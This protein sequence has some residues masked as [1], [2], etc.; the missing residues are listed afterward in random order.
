MESIVVS[1]DDRPYRIGGSFQP[2]V[3]RP[4]LPLRFPC[5][6][7]RFEFPFEYLLGTAYSAAHRAFR[8][9]PV[10]GPRAAATAGRTAHI[11][12][13]AGAAT[14]RANQARRSHAADTNLH[15]LHGIAFPVRRSSQPARCK[16]LTFTGSKAWQ[17]IEI[18]PPGSATVPAGK[19]GSCHG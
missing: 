12:H 15:Q 17:F 10:P 3:S 14:T 9:R 13:P 8:M 16:V 19:Y 2:V 11:Q 4:A 18:R 1:L 6:P 5:R 7:A